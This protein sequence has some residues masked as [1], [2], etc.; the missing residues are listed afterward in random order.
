MMRNGSSKTATQRKVKTYSIFNL[1][2]LS[3]IVSHA[4]DVNQSDHAEHEDLSMRRLRILF[5]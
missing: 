4:D 2:L 1:L 5:S 3:L